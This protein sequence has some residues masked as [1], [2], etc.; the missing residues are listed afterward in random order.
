MNIS[1]S[2]SLKLLPILGDPSLPSLPLP[3]IPGL[4]PAN[5]AVRLG[6]NGPAVLCL[7]MP[8]KGSGRFVGAVELAD[9]SDVCDWTPRS[10]DFF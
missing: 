7:C 4:L 6:D 8:C 9:E 2:R 1:P 10:R 5:S 3:F